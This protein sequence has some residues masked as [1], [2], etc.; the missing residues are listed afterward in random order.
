MRKKRIL[1][2]FPQEWDDLALAR[3]HLAARYEYVRAGFDLFRFPD[4]ARLL[5]F[6]ARRFIERLVRLAQKQRF[7]AVITTNEQFG[8]PIA[9]VIAQRL[10]LPGNDPAAIITAQHKYYARLALSRAVPQATP[11][12]AVFPYSVRDPA[13]IGLRFPF[14]VKPVKATF[15]VLA[16]R[17]DCF[18]ELRR[19]LSFH[20]FEEYIIRR[21]IRPF[22]DLMVDHGGFDIDV[23]HMLA[24]GLADGLQ[25]N[26]D[27]FVESGRVRLIGL[28]DEVLYPGTSAFRRFEYPSSLPLHLQE[29]VR[30]IAAQAIAATGLRHGFFNV[31]LAVNCCKGGDDIRVIEI[32]PRLASQFATL[33]QWVDGI[34]IFE[35]LIDLALG[36]PA[37]DA[38]A[39]QRFT[40]AGSFIFR[41][42][43]G[44]SL[45][46][47]PSRAQLATLRARHPEAELMLYPKRGASLAREMKWLGSH[48]YA[49][50][51]LPGRDLADLYQRCAD[52][53]TLLGFDQEGEPNPLPHAGEGWTSTRPTGH[54]AQPAALRA[55]ELGPYSRVA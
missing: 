20:P 25:V 10:G 8:A 42:F 4:N 35:M 7:D 14:F 30:A 13:A 46:R 54:A 1:V 18:A 41:K 53:R 39:P 27:G 51:N 3:P 34:D 36:E 31:E 22:N 15:S 23:H 48:R 47:P 37:R 5:T 38:P 29:R 2:L 49:I 12:F 26:V 11:P 6:D 44:T 40:R 17:V 55:A 33:Y 21:L 24:E 43:D 45:R 32:N 28:V 19:H 52:M 9:A 16:R 50:L